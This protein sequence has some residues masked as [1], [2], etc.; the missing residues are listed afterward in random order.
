[1]HKQG[2]RKQNFSII[3]GK[4]LYLSHLSRHLSVYFRKK[5]FFFLLGGGGG[6]GGGGG[7]GVNRSLNLTPKIPTQLIVVSQ[8]ENTI[9]FFRFFFPSNISA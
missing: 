4:I 6:G 2:D 8:Q 9:N 3:Q 7:E 5:S 1:M